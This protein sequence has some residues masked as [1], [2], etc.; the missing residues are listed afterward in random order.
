MMIAIFFM[1]AFIQ[2]SDMDRMEQESRQAIDRSLH[3]LSRDG[4]RWIKERG[5]VSCH[6]VPFMIWAHN[7]ARERGF[8]ID[9]AKISATTNWAFVNMFAERKQ[10]GG[11]D[12]ISQMLLGRDRVSPW[13]KK[14]PR[15]FKTVDP[16]ETLFEILLERQSEDGSWPPE[17]QLTT[18]PELT[19]GWAVLT[20]DSRGDKRGDPGI[21]LDP[22]D[23]LGT[24]LGEQLSRLEQQIS[25]TRARA[26]KYLKGVE[27]HQTN[28]GL[29]LRALLQQRYGEGDKDS[30]R[31]KLVA[32]QKADG[33]W[34]NRFDHS[35]S[36]AFATGQVL[37][38]LS[39][40]GDPRD[41]AAIALARGF[42]IRSQRDDGSWY[43]TADRVRAGKRSDS[44]DEVFSYWGTAWASIG[45]LHTM[46]E[47]GR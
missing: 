39:R 26:L 38:A 46:P 2:L 47:D 33:G 13:R 42:L 17:G 23:D 35:K 5:C 41:R 34:A 30:L 28:E 4:D 32:S 8:D 11:A 27:P 40:F 37:Y 31:K 3:F 19:T 20:L 16:Y 15:H 29:V 18:P 22:D 14:P 12:T 43:V 44:L 36:D 25:E 24:E 10:V 45:L 1:I 9:E 21:G 6:H 7:D